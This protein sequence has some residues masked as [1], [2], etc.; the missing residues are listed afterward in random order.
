MSSTITFLPSITFTYEEYTIID[1]DIRSG[2]RQ[3]TTYELEVE[4]NDTVFTIGVSETS[5]Y[6][7]EINDLTDTI[8]SRQVIHSSKWDAPS[9]AC[10]HTTVLNPSS[11]VSV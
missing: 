10:D 1:K 8:C 7:Y 3:I 5:Y 9:K 2:A 4:K 11:T 6:N